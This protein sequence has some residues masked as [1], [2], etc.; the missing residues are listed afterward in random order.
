MTK[1][2]KKDLVVAL[3]AEGLSDYEARATAYINDD[4]PKRT[5]MEHPLPCPNSEYNHHVGKEELRI[6]HIAEGKNKGQFFIECEICHWCG[7]TK[8]TP[9]TA[10]Q[11]WNKDVAKANRERKV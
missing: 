3:K 10:E 1:K 5:G 6:W 7:P 11:A 2:Q 9:V 8:P 4:T